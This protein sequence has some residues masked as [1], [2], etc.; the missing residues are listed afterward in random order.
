MITIIINSIWKMENFF[1]PNRIESSKAEDEPYES[2]GNIARSRLG[3]QAQYASRYVDGFMGEYP[4]CG[5]GLRFKGNTDDYHSLQI[6]PGD[7]E[8]FV[9]RVIEARANQN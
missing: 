1:K 4:N 2:F 9:K 7:V 8:E 6:H 3:M 5:E